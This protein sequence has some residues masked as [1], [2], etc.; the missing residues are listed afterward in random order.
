MQLESFHG[1]GGMISNR[2]YNPSGAYGGLQPARECT[3][4]ANKAYFFMNG[5]AICLGSAVNSTD[6]TN[7][8]TIVENR[9]GDPIIE[10]GRVTGHSEL[11]VTFNG[12]G[13]ELTN[14]DTVYENVKYVTL[15]SDAYCILDGSPIIAKKTEKTEKLPAFTQIVLSHGVNP[16]D[17][18]YAYAI[19]PFAD[20]AK[21]ESFLSDVPFEIVENT[22]AAQVIREKASGY[23]YCVFHQ[24]GETAGIS[25]EV[26]ILCAIKGDTLYA[27]DVTQ[28]LESVTLKVNGKE[29]G[30]DFTKTYGKAQS[31]KL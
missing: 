2:Y 8:Y 9:H 24:A 15:G 29:Y 22:P 26:P 4:T 21:A 30:F 12:K 19:L 11:P 14:T 20:A 18:G 28:K 16:V 6:G 10:N 25:T 31:V 13:V 5:Y 17:K 23:L 1:D 3:L 27:C 7:V